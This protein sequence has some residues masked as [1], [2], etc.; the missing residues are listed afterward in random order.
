MSSCTLVF[1]D[2]S[3][4]YLLAVTNHLVGDL[5]EEVR[6]AILGVVV[7]SDGVDHLDGVHESGESVDD[8]RCGP[9]V[10]RLDEAL[11]GEKIFYIILGL[12]GVLSDLHVNILPALD[13]VLNLVLGKI[14]VGLREGG[15]QTVDLFAVLALELLSDG[16]QALH[17]VAPKL[18]LGLGASVA[19]SRGVSIKVLIDLVA[20]LLQQ[21][22]EVRDE[23]GHGI[24]AL[25]EV[26]SIE[27]LVT[28]DLVSV[29]ATKLQS[30]GKGLDRILQ[31]SLEVLHLSS[32][33]RLLLVINLAPFGGLQGGRGGGRGGGRVRR[34]ERKERRRYSIRRTW[35]NSSP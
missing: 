30:A 1:Y 26:A 14:R 4:P 19:G 21:L 6:H 18:E 17:A 31:D 32:K 28:L 35:T 29:G 7:T 11:E 2:H 5:G 9:R 15:K 22:L 25:L 34:E 20:P 13:E 24:D 27:R 8:R 23:V 33:V 12:V 16:G 10:Q 3:R